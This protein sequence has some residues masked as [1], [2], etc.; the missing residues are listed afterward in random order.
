MYGCSVYTTLS[1]RRT[2]DEYIGS[3]P[4]GNS[5]PIPGSREHG[6]HDRTPRNR[7]PSVFKPSLVSS[8]KTPGGF[9]EGGGVRDVSSLRTE[10]TG[11]EKGKTSRDEVAQMV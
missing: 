7:N 6:V 10:T 11:E 8:G 4:I 5:L 2:V 9:D 3:G 1:T